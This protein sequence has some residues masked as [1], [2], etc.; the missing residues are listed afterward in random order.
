MMTVIGIGEKL[1]NYWKIVCYCLPW[2]SEKQRQVGGQRWEVHWEG[3]KQLMANRQ[4]MPFTVGLDDVTPYMFGNLMGPP[5][6]ISVILVPPQFNHS[7]WGRESTW[8]ERQCPT[9]NGSSRSPNE[10]TRITEALD[11]IIPSSRLVVSF[12]WTRTDDLVYLVLNYEWMT[13]HR[14]RR[15]FSQGLRDQCW[16]KKACQY[17]LIRQSWVQCRTTFWLERDYTTRGTK[18][19]GTWCD[20]RWLNDT[21]FH[22]SPL[23]V[24]IK[25]KV[26]N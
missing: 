12:T 3:P 9:I 22:L 14:L 2:E 7:C 16:W 13:S 5:I 26:I 6:T 19:L 17:N 1:V 18:N 4:R 23:V 10:S 25:P 24:V 21:A 15:K 8:H 11:A 20:Q